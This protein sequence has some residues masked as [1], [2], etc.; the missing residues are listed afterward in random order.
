MPQ[1]LHVMYMHMSIAGFDAWMCM[2]RVCIR[3]RSM[4]L[5]SYIHKQSFD[6]LIERQLRLRRAWQHSKRVWRR[7]HTLHGASNTSYDIVIVK[8]ILVRRLQALHGVLI[9]MIKH[10]R[11]LQALHRVLIL[12]HIRRA[13]VWRQNIEECQVWTLIHVQRAFQSVSRRWKTLD[14][15]CLDSVTC[16]PPHHHARFASATLSFLSWSRFWSVQWLVTVWMRST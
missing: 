11:R 16:E 7:S 9:I 3:R 10:T 4:I 14:K 1:V 15:T 5:V 12:K 13:N 8:V 6:A 2:M